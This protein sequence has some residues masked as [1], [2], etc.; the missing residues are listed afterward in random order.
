[1]KLKSVQSIITSS[2]RVVLYNGDFEQW[3]GDGCAA[4]PL[5]GLPQ[6]RE[7]NLK[8]FLDV[9][10]EQYEKFKSEE[11]DADFIFDDNSDNE[12]ELSAMNI[13]L[14]YRGIEVIPLKGKQQF[15]IKLK[16]LK[17][18]KNTY[19][20]RYFVRRDRSGQVYIAV[21]EGFT[22]RAVIIPE[23]LVDEELVDIMKSLYAN[24]VEEL[25]RIRQQEQEEEKAENLKNLRFMDGE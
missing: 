21:K 23:S 5:Y 7:I 4:Y 22:L 15:F 20:L 9:T 10:D 16:Y 1:M 17:P 11:Q 3:I 2:K 8:A 13:T 19:L 18:F 24:C 6:L 14:N 25:N 12:S